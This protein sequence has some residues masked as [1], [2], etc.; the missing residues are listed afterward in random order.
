MF[1]QSSAGP[2]AAGEVSRR[3]GRRCKPRGSGHSDVA[4]AARPPDAANAWTS[5]PAPPVSNTSQL[6][7][8]RFAQNLTAT[9]SQ[10]TLSTS[11]SSPRN[12]SKI[13][14]SF[15][16]DLRLPAT[17]KTVEHYY[18]GTAQLPFCCRPQTATPKGFFFFFFLNINIISQ[19][20]KNRKE[21]AAIFDKYQGEYPYTA[22]MKCAHTHALEFKLYRNYFLNIEDT[23][24]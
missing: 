11:R 2:Q 23:N 20:K 15:C 8:G 12:V 1:L 14:S 16:E 22:Q 4:G 5:L 24:A 18:K 13:C 19:L 3:C 7:S 6:P 17:R 10:N 9:P 21:E